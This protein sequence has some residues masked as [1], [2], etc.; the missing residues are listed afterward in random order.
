VPEPFDAVV[1]VE[2]IAEQGA[3]YRIGRALPPGSNVRPV[4]EDVMIGQIVAREGERLTFA[5][6]PLL[7]A[8]GIGRV[9]VR[10]L[11]RTCYIPTGEEIVSP[12]RWLN[13]APQGGEVAESNSLFLKA[14]FLRWSWPFDVLPIVPDD[15][16]LLRSA[17]ETALER[18][19]LILLG[20]GSAK[21]KR[22]HSARVLGELGR[23]LFHWLRLKPGRPALAAEANRK[24]LICLPGF[25]ASTA[26][27]FWDL[28]L[29]LLRRLAGMDPAGEE[30]PAPPYRGTLEARLLLPHSSPVGMEE[31]LRVQLAQIDDT[32]WAWATGAGASSLS[33]TAEADGI[34]RLPRETLE[35]PKGLPLTVRLLRRPD[36][37]RRALFQGS[38]DPAIQRLVGPIR[39]RG[40]DLVIRPT[41]SLGGLAALSRGEAHLAACHLLDPESGGYNDTYL[42]RFDPEGR[43]SRRV[44][45]LRTQGILAAPGNPKGIRGIADLGR[46]IRL[47]NRQ[48]G[49]GTRVLLDHLLDREGIDRREVAGYETIS[50]THLDA[51]NRIASGVADAAL[52]IK[53]AADALGLDFIPLAEE[54]YELVIPRKYLDHLAVTALL[55]AL[56]DADWRSRVER[57]GGYRWP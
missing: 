48:P 30:D 31:I 35:A 3:G 11:P 5:H 8:A 15:P 52:G 42:A 43:W 44:A 18:Y 51:A 50:L 49:A 45:F 19:D 53:A 26:V 28:A 16:A 34:A 6:L 24:P 12:E 13:E 57:M 56:D 54:P 25:P 27:V 14:H 29:P 46:G 32:L 38:D 22:D 36:I 10:S 55:E 23:I 39:R 17:L 7:L 21:G 40:G 20:A 9:L 4:G 33:A 41:G 37:G 47:V 1:M 2:D